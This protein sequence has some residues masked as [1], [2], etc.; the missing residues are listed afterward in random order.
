MG[1]AEEGERQVPSPKERVSGTQT[2]NSAAGRMPYIVVSCSS[3]SQVEMG[4][5]FEF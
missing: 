1:I 2:L 4:P 3:L 5:K